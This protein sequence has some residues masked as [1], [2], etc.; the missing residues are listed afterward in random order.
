MALLD[1]ELLFCDDQA[2]TDTGTSNS[3]N[4]IDT[5]IGEDVWGASRAKNPGEGGDIWLHA[6]VTTAFASDSP[7][8]ASFQVD[9]YEGD[10]ATPNTGFT[11]TTHSV[12][13]LKVASLTEGYSVF[14]VP[15][16]VE[17]KRYLK[18]L[19]TVSGAAFTAGKIT[20]WLSADGAGSKST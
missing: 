2:L 12:S 4:L 18:L 10:A 7:A 9:V 3:T 19:F 14:R 1:G 20:A 5:T 8:T 11:A 13:G 17:V 15:L 6:R 16:A